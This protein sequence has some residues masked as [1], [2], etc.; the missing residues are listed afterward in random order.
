MDVHGN[1]KS[2]PSQ[3]SGQK[4]CYSGGL[5]AGWP[6]FDSWHGKMFLFS[7][8][9]RLTLGSTKL[10][11]QSVPGTPSLK[12]KKAGREAQLSPPFNAEVKNG[13]AMLPLPRVSS[14]HSA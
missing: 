3:E 11:V 2:I 10:P 8:A 13:G 1:V 7:T 4:S 5:R 14:W 12:I 9:S 6:R